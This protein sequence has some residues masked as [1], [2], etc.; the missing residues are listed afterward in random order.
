MKPIELA[1]IGIRLIALSLL[2]TSLNAMFQIFN[3]IDRMMQAY[4]VYGP[5]N[6]L[7][8]SLLFAGVALSV[9][10]PLIAIAVWRYSTA[11]ARFLLPREF[12]SPL[13]IGINAE[14]LEI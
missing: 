12:D 2:L 5:A 13:N 8:K 14:E 11:I 10:L 4:D 3:S 1:S 9:L 6:S 7:Q